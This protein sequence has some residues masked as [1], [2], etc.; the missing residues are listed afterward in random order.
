[1][2]IRKSLDKSLADRVL[3]VGRNPEGLCVY[4]AFLS[5]TDYYDGE[6]P[7]DDARAIKRLQLRTVHGHVFGEKGELEQEF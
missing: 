3:V 6:H 4:T 7:W 2:A 5:A 1:M